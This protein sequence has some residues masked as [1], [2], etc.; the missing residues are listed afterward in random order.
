LSGALLSA[1]VLSHVLA[2]ALGGWP[3]VLV[4][5]ALAGGYVA[6]RELQSGP[7]PAR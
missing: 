7:A 2:L 3:S 5:A 4:C 6:A 1:F